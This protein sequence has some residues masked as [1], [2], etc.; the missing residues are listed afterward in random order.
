MSRPPQMM[1]SRH[2]T[3]HASSCNIEHQTPAQN[4]V[5]SN[6]WPGTA[7]PGRAL[8]ARLH[9][10]LRKCGAS[11]DGANGGAR[12]CH[13]WSLNR[14]PVTIVGAARRERSA[15][16]SLS[17]RMLGLGG[18]LRSIRFAWVGWGAP[19]RWCWVCAERTA[20][21]CG[22]GV[23]LALVGGSCSVLFS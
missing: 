7:V 3:H 14:A 12:R 10:L 1:Q 2:T 8:S 20:G 16:L 11:A 9:H 18:I 23:R 17:E 22:C 21:L 6:R 15:S 13:T 5:T 19:V 4:L